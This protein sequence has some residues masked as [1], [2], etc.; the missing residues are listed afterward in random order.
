MNKVKT[1]SEA[2]YNVSKTSKASKLADENKI[3]NQAI[4]IIQ[5][6]LEKNKAEIM[7]SSPT[8][9]KDF[10][11]LKL[12]EEHNES[13]H[14]L[15]LNNQHGLIAEEKLFSGTID[16]C[17]VHVRVLAKRA[18]ELN[19]NAVIL[20]HNHPSG[21]C[22]ASNAD[23][24]MTKRIKNALDMLEIRT[25]DHIIVGGSKTLSLAETGDM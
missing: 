10:L 21:L 17:S 13:F 2:T 6:R 9:V 3:I 19:A 23:I 22:E 1:E 15:F 5:K 11:V 25:L 12:A 16:S 14:V 8:I 7:F 18:L 4:S 20:A 24:A